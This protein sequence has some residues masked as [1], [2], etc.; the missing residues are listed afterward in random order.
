MITGALSAAS[1]SAESIEIRLDWTAGPISIEIHDR[2]PGFP[3]G[4]LTQG[5]RVEFPAHE[6]G[7]GIGLMLTRSAI[8]Q[9]GGR[10]LLLNPPAG[11]AVARLELPRGT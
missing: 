5:G 6:H 4:V 11:G 7:S 10:L 2:G 8:E 3:A 9:I 1:A